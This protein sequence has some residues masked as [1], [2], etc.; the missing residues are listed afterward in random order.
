MDKGFQKNMFEK[1]IQHH[2]SSETTP[3]SGAICT[4]SMKTKSDILLESNLSLRGAVLKYEIQEDL[5]FPFN[6]INSCLSSMHTGETSLFTFEGGDGCNEETCVTI[7]LHNFENYPLEIYNLTNSQKRDKALFYKET[8][9][10]MFKAG[11]IQIAFD[12]FSTS[13]KFLIMLNPHDDVPEDCPT[14]QCQCY[15]NLAACQLKY[16]TSMRS[17]IENCTRALVLDDANI[18]GYVRRGQAYLAKGEYSNAICDFKKALTIEPNN[19]FVQKLLLQ[20]G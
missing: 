19:K 4:V 2:G 12:N 16:P 7:T 13:L 20:A 18:K 3:Q 9:V 17:V 1:Q 6:N 5:Q 15:L 8:G 10:K 14:L 11:S